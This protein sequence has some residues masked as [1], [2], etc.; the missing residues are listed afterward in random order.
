MILG[1]TVSDLEVAPGRILKPCLKIGGKRQ[2][3]TIRRRSSGLGAGRVVSRKG[4]TAD[5]PEAA[6]GIPE[7]VMEIPEM[8]VGLPEAVMDI[9]E[10]VANVGGL[11]PREGE[12]GAEKAEAVQEVDKSKVR[13]RCEKCTATG[14]EVGLSAFPPESWTEAF[15]R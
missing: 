9:P 5:I 3:R 11:D 1:S 4:R 12:E 6:T 7:A 2:Q 13:D 14:A 10:V 15:G 8:S